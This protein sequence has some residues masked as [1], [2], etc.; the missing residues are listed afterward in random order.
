MDS[1]SIEVKKS[2]ESIEINKDDNELPPSPEVLKIRGKPMDINEVV[3]ESR[4][5]NDSKILEQ[6]L[7]EEQG[8]SDFRFKLHGSRS[9]RKQA[10]EDRKRLAN[11]IQLLKLEEQRVCIL[12]KHLVGIKE[13]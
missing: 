11:R 10:E 5:A 2:E 13:I 9:A 3:D 1:E 4:I 8:H 7:I 6:N 12:V